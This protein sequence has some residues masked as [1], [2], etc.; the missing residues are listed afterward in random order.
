M[1]CANCRSFNPDDNHYCENC[2]TFLDAQRVRELCLKDV[3]NQTQLRI[4]TV[5][6][7]IGS[8]KMRS[9]GLVNSKSVSRCHAR[10]TGSGV[11]FYITDLNSTNGTYI[12]EERIVPG[13][14][15]KLEDKMDVRLA[16]YTFTVE[17]I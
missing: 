2:G 1:F 14:P 17:L 5:P 11:D 13:K 8:S 15:I 6:Y 9:Q 3:K 4:P 7:V 10:I 16:D 12:N